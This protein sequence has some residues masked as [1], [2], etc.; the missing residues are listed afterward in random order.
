MNLMPE[1]FLGVRRRRFVGAEVEDEILGDEEE[2]LRALGKKKTKMPIPSTHL[3]VTTQ[4]TT[5]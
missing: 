2:T 4:K 3:V 1:F 5:F